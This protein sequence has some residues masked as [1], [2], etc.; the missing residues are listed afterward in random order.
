MW[1]Q[2]GHQ[3]APCGS[4]PQPGNMRHQI[5]PALRQRRRDVD[6]AAEPTLRQHSDVCITALQQKPVATQGREREAARTPK[7]SRTWRLRESPTGR[8][9]CDVRPRRSHPIQRHHGSLQG[10]VAQLHRSRTFRQKSRAPTTLMSNHKRGRSSKCKVQTKYVC[11]PICSKADLC[12]VRPL[13]SHPAPKHRLRSRRSARK[14]DDLRGF[15]KIVAPSPIKTASRAGRQASSSA[16]R[17]GCKE[18][19]AQRNQHTDAEI[20]PSGEDELIGCLRSSA[21]NRK[22]GRPSQVQKSAST[23]RSRPRAR[24]L[25]SAPT[26]QPPGAVHYTAFAHEHAIHVRSFNCCIL[27]C[28]RVAQGCRTGMDT[29]RRKERLPNE[30][31]RTQQQR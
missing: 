16:V 8:S 25:P 11:P 21:A 17:E 20:A 24:P 15:M 19:H 14:L 3:S 30:R 26:R 7:S 10:F 6:C 2:E 4:K 28:I 5:D 1:R 27:S 31:P 22:R 29:Q 9:L 18:S 12:Q 23:H 13:D